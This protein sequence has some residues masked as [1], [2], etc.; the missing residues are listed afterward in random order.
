MVRVWREVK[1][2]LFLR[3]RELANGGCDCLLV[4]LRIFIAIHKRKSRLN[5]VRQGVI[6]LIILS[7]EL[8]RDLG[9][10]DGTIS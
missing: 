10:F 2:G 5:H 8:S 9:Y 6:I 4:A 7:R 1:H 3:S